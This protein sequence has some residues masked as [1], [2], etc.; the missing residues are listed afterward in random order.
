MERQSHR[1]IIDNS[2]STN[3]VS[4]LSVNKIIFDIFFFLYS[5]VSM[6]RD[7]LTRP[8]D[9]LP[10]R[11]S[12]S[13]CTIT[14]VPRLTA[15]FL[16]KEIIIVLLRRCNCYQTPTI[17]QWT[18]KQGVYYTVFRYSKT[19]RSFCLVCSCKLKF[20]SCEKYC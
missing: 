12:L 19:F 13:V 10:T 18:T 1:S 6:D 16:V 8:N 7:S 5:P 20:A 11:L 17:L 4:S 3:S 15:S 14:Q 9:P 2:V